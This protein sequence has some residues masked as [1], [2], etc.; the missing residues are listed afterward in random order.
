[1][2]VRKTAKVESRHLRWGLL[3]IVA[4]LLSLSI[5][6]LGL[7]GAS[8]D[9]ARDFYGLSSA[10][11][12]AVYYM[13]YA[14]FAIGL[15]VGYAILHFSG[16]CALVY[17]AAGLQIIGYGVQLAYQYSFWPVII[18]GMI[19]DS[20][21]AFMWLGTPTFVARWFETEL[22]SI[23]YGTIFF[24][25]S[26]VAL[27]VVA[28]VR[29][30][31]E[32][33]NEYH[34]RLMWYLVSFLA[35][36]IIVF[37]TS[38]LT[39]VEAPRKPPGPQSTA[40]RTGVPRDTICK[41]Q[42]PEENR[43]NIIIVI[44]VYI[45]SV[46]PTWAMSSLALAIMNNHDYS[47]SDISLVAVCGLVASM[48][49]PIIVGPLQSLTRQYLWIAIGTILATTAIYAV[50]PGVLETRNAF[51]GIITTFMFVTGAYSITF[52]ECAVELS[53][54]VPEKYVSFIMF[55][56]AQFSG[57]LCTLFASFN[58]TFTAAMWLFLALFGA[59][60]A[61]LIIG[62]L[63]FP[64]KFTRVAEKGTSTRRVGGSDGYEEVSMQ[65]P[66]PVY[67]RSV[68]AQAPAAYNRSG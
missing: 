31:I 66:P 20:T 32:N 25:A 39:F 23:A 13:A 14:D 48:F 6:G 2:Q 62:V 61:V 9:S 38:L 5:G 35:V 59:S 50:L 33:A 41:P 11:F 28:A 4:I 19:V 47:N 53:F 55:M 40:R 44:V 45:V 68:P 12:N 65:G 43:P 16:L 26:V 58:A 1:M 30:S 22:K 52:I 34:D 15:V 37:V 24:S 42:W 21:R 3:A 49:M 8:V 27:G 60:A 7:T 56:G 17:F 63:C 57:V 18:G 67:L 36:D 46:G 10:S 64:S 29:Y 54:P 51:I